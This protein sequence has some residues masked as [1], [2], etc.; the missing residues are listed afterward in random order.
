MRHA[1]QLNVVQIEAIRLGALTIL[2]TGWVFLLLE[3]GIIEKLPVVAWLLVPIG[4]TFVAGFAAVTRLS[5][6]YRPWEIT[7]NSETFAQV[8][9]AHPDPE[10]LAA[11]EAEEEPV[12]TDSEMD[13]ENNWRNRVRS[14]MR[15]WVGLPPEKEEVELK[16]GD[17][18]DLVRSRAF[19]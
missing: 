5:S 6:R 19:L 2:P 8:N 17:A 4:L 15:D 11:D 12:E 14:F 7:L 13:D 9:F 18:A 10:E 1:G 3:F 16:P